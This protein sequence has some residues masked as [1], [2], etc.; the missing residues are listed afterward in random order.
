MAVATGRSPTAGR[1]TLGRSPSTLRGIER[2]GFIGP[3]YG[4]E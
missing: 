4:H 2:T 1:R 3:W